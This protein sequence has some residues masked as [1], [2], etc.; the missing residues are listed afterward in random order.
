MRLLISMDHSPKQQPIDALAHR[1]AT[2]SVQWAIA[3]ALVILFA[4]GIAAFI[5]KVQ[6]T[7][8][9][10]FVILTIGAGSALLIALQISMMGWSRWLILIFLAL[11]GLFHAASLFAGLF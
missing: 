4:E 9:M 7:R 2:N 1:R 6:I 10:G 3:L 5:F 11:S 8:P